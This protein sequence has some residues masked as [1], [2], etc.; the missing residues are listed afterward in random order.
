MRS[1]ILVFQG[2]LSCMYFSHSRDPHLYY[3]RY[4]RVVAL[5]DGSAAPFAAGLEAVMAAQ[6]RAAQAGQQQQQRD[7]RRRESQLAQASQGSRSGSRF[8]PRTA[9]HAFRSF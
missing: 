5:D 4:R 6:E 7:L 1:D 8:K 9:R 3:G 2:P